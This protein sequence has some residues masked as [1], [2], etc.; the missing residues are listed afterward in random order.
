MQLEITLKTINNEELIIPLHYNYLVQ[1][2]I[3]QS[4]E[5]NLSEFLHNCGFKQGKRSFKMFTF[6]RLLGKFKINKDKKKII[7]TGPV[8]LI[9]SSPM[10]EFCNSLLNN[11]LL[12]GELTLG[13]N[14]IIVTEVK[15]KKTEVKKEEVSLKVLSPVV[16]YSTFFRPDGRKYTCYFQPGDPEYEELLENNLRKKYKAFYDKEPPKGKIKV[17]TFGQPRLSV[18]RYKGTIIKGY[19]GKLALEGPQELLQTAID[20]GLGSKNA[21]GFGCVE[22]IERR[23]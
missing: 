10:E 7:F 3:Y 9:I 17:R 20:T 12:K 23:C 18:I 22:L 5:S 2:A 16:L 8:R 6:S 19:T 13:K 15:G 4:L 1:A 11:L 14:K 21:Q